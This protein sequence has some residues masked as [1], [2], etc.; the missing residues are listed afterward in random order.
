MCSGIGVSKGIARGKVS[1]C[2]DSCCTYE[3]IEIQDVT[4]EKEY[5]RQAFIRTAEE[6]KNLY[7]LASKRVGLSVAVIIQGHRL[8]I[9]DQ[10]CLNQVLDLIETQEVNAEWAI[11]QVFQQYMQ[12]MQKIQDTYLSA[13]IADFQDILDRV[14][15]AMRGVKQSSEVIKKFDQH[16][17]PFIA[18]GRE[19]SVEDILALYEEGAA[20]ILDLSGDEES[21]ALVVAKSLDL[22]MIIKVSEDCFSLVGKHCLMDGARGSIR[23]E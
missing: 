23:A 6:F 4:V 3:K 17:Q 9:E 14:E 7:E 8:M 19:F 20:G 5:A 22:P 18:I 12:K 2:K 16:N 10:G 11:Q 15:E 21:H 13:R 1:V